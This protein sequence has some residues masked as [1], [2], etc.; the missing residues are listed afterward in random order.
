MITVIIPCYNEE[1]TIH[2]VLNDVVTIF[3]NAQIIVVDNNSTDNSRNIIKNIRFQ[4]RNIDFFICGKK[5][6][7]SAIL[8]VIKSIKYETVILIDADLEYQI[9]SISQLLEIH[10]NKNADMT[11][12]VRNSKLMTSFFANLL[13]SQIFKIRFGK[14][15]SDVLTGAR[16]VKKS[17][18]MQCKSSKFGLETE[19]TKLALMQNLNIVEDNCLYCPRTIGKKIRPW[20]L[21]E[22]VKIAIC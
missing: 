4:H 15:V 9:L 14:T 6:K 10:N 18:L 19:L 12:G 5:G 20:D 1:H 16:I 17:L 2:S 22:L 13:L 21:F 7:S 11:I 8:S 3:K